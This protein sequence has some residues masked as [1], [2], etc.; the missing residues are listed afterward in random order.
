M[1]RPLSLVRRVRHRA[2]LVRQE[3][4]ILVITAVAMTV[5]IGFAAFAI[6]LG[7]WWV[8][9]RHLQT[10]ADAAAFAGGQKLLREYIDNNCANSDVT[11]EVQRYDGAGQANYTP[12]GSG[13]AVNLNQQVPSVPT[14]GGTSYT[15]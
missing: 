14:Y 9:A 11:A 6:D 3:G 4:Q 8:H 13:T 5:M 7:I 10:Q 2:L 15:S 1:L 12:A